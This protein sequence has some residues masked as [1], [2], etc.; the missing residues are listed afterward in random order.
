[1]YKKSKSLT[2]FIANPND[3]IYRQS[4]RR[5]L[6][7]DDTSP[8]DI[9]QHP[10]LHLDGVPI[11]M[12]MHDND[13]V[14]PNEFKKA[15]HEIDVHTQMAMGQGHNTD[16]FWA[17][18]LDKTG[19]GE[20]IQKAYDAPSGIA[21]RI[22]P[23]TGENQMAI[24]GSRNLF[25]WG[26]NFL[27]SRGPLGINEINPGHHIALAVRKKRAAQILRIAEEANVDRIIAHSRASAIASDMD[28]KIPIMALD[29][30]T[31]IENH[32]TKNRKTFLNLSTGG[33]FDK[34]L[35]Q[36]GKGVVDIPGRK[37]HDVASSKKKSILKTANRFKKFTDKKLD[38]RKPKAYK[39]L[40][41]GP[42]E[43]FARELGISQKP[44]A[45]L[46]KR[47]N[48]FEDR[49]GS[50]RRLTDIV[51]DRGNS[52]LTKLGTKRQKMVSGEPR[53][54]YQELPFAVGKSGKKKK[55]KGL[56]RKVL[57]GGSKLVYKTF[58]KTGQLAINEA[59]AAAK[60]A[61][62]EALGL[63][64]GMP[65]SRAPR[66]GQYI[67][68][69]EPISQDRLMDNDME[70]VYDIQAFPSGS[71]SDYYKYYD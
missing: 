9:T 6:E 60:I 61:F 69:D 65:H 42:H 51:K 56:L 63:P 45:R 15:R 10:N 57:G 3:E 44:I 59:K 33:K 43:E 50:N 31:R 64:P 20:Y 35:S 12:V 71:P 4:R 67:R 55:K 34:F 29:G 23:V 30:A 13:L 36:G 2:N 70:D 39:S 27:E 24:A 48:L 8:N 58:K 68:P 46:T 38:T 19:M 11:D 16:P 47:G 66:R 14:L 18:Y 32:H 62:N 25:D 52:Y 17:P 54:K 7:K 37:F 22:D 28:T 1:M 40:G 21:L 41:L 5:Q 53:F 26:A 49:F